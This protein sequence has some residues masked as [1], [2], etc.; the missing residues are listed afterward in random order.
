MNELTSLFDNGIIE[1]LFFYKIPKY[2]EFGIKK[3]KS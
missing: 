3:R 2:H 1:Q